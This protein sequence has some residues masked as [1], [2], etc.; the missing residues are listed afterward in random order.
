[1]RRMKRLLLILPALA[2]AFLLLLRPAGPGAAPPTPA[3][4]LAAAVFAGGCVWCTEA[5]CD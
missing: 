2:G 4:K 1:M 5:G 3:P